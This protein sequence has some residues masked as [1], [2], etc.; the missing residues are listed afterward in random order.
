MKATKCKKTLSHFSKS[1][2]C[3]SATW[4]ACKSERNRNLKGPWAQE[5]EGASKQ[6]RK[7]DH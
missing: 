1:L 6:Q 2:A 3:V 7:N 4:F 5:S